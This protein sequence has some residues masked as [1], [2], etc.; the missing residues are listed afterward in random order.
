MSSIFKTSNGRHQYPFSNLSLNT[1]LHGKFSPFSSPC[2]KTVPTAASLKLE[3]HSKDITDLKAF[4]DKYQVDD[5][6]PPISAFRLITLPAPKLF[7]SLNDLDQVDFPVLSYTISEITNFSAMI[8]DSS[9]VRKAIGK[10]FNLSKLMQLIAENYNVTAYHNFT[11]AFS[12][13]LVSRH[14]CS[15][16]GRPTTA[17]KSY[18]DSSTRSSGSMSS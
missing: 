15:S 7:V 2:H 8:L 18:E 10:S 12:L 3:K 1:P 6:N 17:A 16:S 9:P 4:K 5:R 13:L 14:L 11:H